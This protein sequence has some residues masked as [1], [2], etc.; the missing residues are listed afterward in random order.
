M[1]GLRTLLSSDRPAP[2]EP[3]DG[4]QCYAC[5][6]SN[7]EMC[8]SRDFT[9]ETC[10]QTGIGPVEVERSPRAAAEDGERIRFTS[11]TIEGLIGPTRL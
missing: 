1:I 2:G 7:N 3:I 10:L 4:R 11:K 8:D 6:T 9:A 5:E